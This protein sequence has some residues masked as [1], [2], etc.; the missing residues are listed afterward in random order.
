MNLNIKEIYTIEMCGVNENQPIVVSHYVDRVFINSK[1]PQYHVFACK[2][3]E[4]SNHYFIDEGETEVFFERKIVEREVSLEKKNAGKNNEVE[5]SIKVIQENDLWIAISER[6]DFPF[7]SQTTTVEELVN[8]VFKL[9]LSCV[10]L[11]LK[12]EK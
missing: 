4:C 8:S 2:H 3:D 11:N 1:N 6:P 7:A 12:K 5:N 9:T 10:E